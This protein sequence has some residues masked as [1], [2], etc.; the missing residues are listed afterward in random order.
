MAAAAEQAVVDR[1][2]NSAGTG[3]RPHAEA[4][5]DTA[6]E[7]APVP[8]LLLL[9]LS[10]AAS[11]S[12]LAAEGP[13]HWGDGVQHHPPCSET[14]GCLGAQSTLGAKAGENRRKG[15]ERGKPCC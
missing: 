9:C 7:E 5:I 3:R 12:P 6:E 11:P 1:V 2:E 10:S 13:P 8:G 14:L 4:S 15:E